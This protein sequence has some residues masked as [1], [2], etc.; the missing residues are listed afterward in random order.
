MRM[1]VAEH[2]TTLRERAEGSESKLQTFRDGWRI[3]RTILILIKEE[4]PLS[5]FVV[6]GA[7]FA[8]ISVSIAV[9]V[10]IEFIETDKIQRLPTLLLS[11]GLMILSFLSLANGLILD[12]VTR[13][14]RELKRLHYLSYKAPGYFD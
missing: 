6:V 7:L 1:K 10:I 5:F 3:L 4:R 9:P 11:T 8:V 12:T 14:R 13:S 2:K